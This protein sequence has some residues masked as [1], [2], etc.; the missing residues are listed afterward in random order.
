MPCVMHSHFHH[1]FHDENESVGGI[2]NVV[3]MLLIK[4]NVNFSAIPQQRSNV[5]AKCIC[6]LVGNMFDCI[7]P[8]HQ[9]PVD[10]AGL[11]QNA[12]RDACPQ[13]NSAANLRF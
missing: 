1:S 2:F 11:L 12:K 13:S 9:F 3:K 8:D 6:S 5:D 7:R 4:T 10:L